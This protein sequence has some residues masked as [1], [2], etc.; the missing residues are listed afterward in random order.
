MYIHAIFLTNDFIEHKSFVALHVVHTKF[1]NG[2][3]P[4]YVLDKL[5]T[6]LLTDQGNFFCAMLNNIQRNVGV[7]CAV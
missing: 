2:K 1:E 3:L 7:C 6:L 4:L 5:N